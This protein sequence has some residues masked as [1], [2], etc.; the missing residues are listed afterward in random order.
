M[1]KI[2]T[3]IALVLGLGCSSLMAQVTYI[4][5]NASVH[6]T[7]VSGPGGAMAILDD[8]T[9]TGSYS[10]GHDYWVTIESNCDSM[11]TTGVKHICFDVQDI[12]I[13]CNDTLYL[14]DGPN[15][16]SPV[17]LKINN[18]YASATGTRF[19]IGPNNTT[20][21]ITLRFR[22]SVGASKPAGFKVTVDCGKPC[23]RITAVIDSMYER[24]NLRTGEVIARSYLKWVPAQIDTIY[25]ADSTEY[26]LD[27]VDWVEGALLCIGQGVRFYG[28]GEYTH[29]TGRYNPTDETSKFFWH[30]GPSDTLFQ[31]G[32]TRVRYDKFQTT[33]C[34]DVTL[35]I[36]DS[37]GCSTTMTPKIQVR[38]A[39]N[40]IKTIYDLANIC[41]SDSLLVNV[42][43]S[44]EN[45]TLTLKR[46]SFAKVVS[47]TNNVRTFIPDGECDGVLCYE[48]PVVFNEFPNGKTITSAGDICSVCINYEHSFMGDYR[49]ALRCPLFD[50][51]VSPTAYQAVL[52]YGKYGQGG[53]TD[54]L[55]PEGSPDGTSAGSGTFTGW[56]LDYVG[57]TS[58]DSSPKCDSLQNPFGIGLDYCWSRNHQ[59]T[60]VTGDLASVPTRFQPGNWYI[61][62]TGVNTISENVTFPTIPSYFTNHGGDTPQGQLTT[63]TPSNHEDMTD[64][65]S[66]ASD[67]SEL[68]GCPLN[69]EWKAVLCDF[70][71]ADNGWVFSWS[72]DICNVSSGGGGCNYQ[73]SIDSVLWH[74]DTNYQR[75]FVHGYYRGI[76][77]REKSGDPTA[78]YISS[79]DTAGSFR[80]NL[81]IYDEFGCRWDTATHITTVY[82]P[83][84]N[85]GDD[86]MLCSVN[87]IKLDATDRFSSSPSAHYQYQWSPYGQKTSQINTTTNA[88]GDVQYVVAVTNSASTKQCEGR[89]T[90]MVRM[91]DQPIPNFDPGIFPLE[92]C[93]PLTLHINNTTKYGYKY[94]W[95]FGDGVISNEKDPIHSYGVGDYDF[96]YYVESEKGCKDSLIYNNLVHVYPNPQAAFS[97]EPTFPTVTSPSIKLENR[98]SPDDASNSYF[99]EIQYDPERPYSFHTMVDHD[100]EFT[101]DRKY[102]AGGK[103]EGGYVVRLIARSSN[104]TNTGRKIECADTVENTILL[105]NDYLQ[106]PSVV[107]P[108]GDG[109]NDRFVIINL[110]EGL[111]YPHN[112]LDIYDKWGSRVFHAVD[113]NKDD[114]FWDPAKTNAPAGSYFYRFS[115]KGYKG[116]IE[117]NGVIEVLR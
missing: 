86:T 81:L 35:S 61:S 115:A 56:P 97:W 71:G 13:D 95:E 102:I 24:I 79:H 5:L 63:R 87:F 89:D 65:Y 22:T 113:I 16:S 14:Y 55:A 68:I 77:I 37:N 51:N 17:M 26:Y 23:E 12:D 80:V 41:N 48:A 6:G 109:I 60:L 29:N 25:N 101:W 99:W 78:A 98:T 110:V 49:I 3:L 108:N 105:I 76:Q 64:Y 20:G 10:G 85:L 52:K 11:D 45:S 39:Q 104:I 116:N 111:A 28:H 70:W 112:Q 54:P 93:A 2:F 47:K 72:L 88:G 33:D 53:T 74:P 21:K 59:Y 92:G 46:I 94:R 75:D 62:A 44:G 27:T 9:D 8:G 90:I 57:S 50:E 31:V 30:L 34:S 117:H 91:N 82:T 36:T 38:V 32:A 19:Y 40:P 83:E 18:C 69:G 1:K 15:T 96:K 84:P 103:N 58:Y 107:T 106:F 114:Q 4:N 66:P 42:G 67:F 43:Y 100:P 73:V 7:T